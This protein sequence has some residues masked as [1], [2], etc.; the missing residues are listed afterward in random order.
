MDN[1]EFLLSNHLPGHHGVPKPS[2]KLKGKSHKESL[3]DS[4]QRCPNHG[5]S[6]SDR[7]HHSKDVILIGKKD[8]GNIIPPDYHADVKDDAKGF[9]GDTT[10]LVERAYAP[11]SALRQN[12]PYFFGVYDPNVA[13]RYNQDFDITFP[14]FNHFENEALIHS[15]EAHHEKNMPA[16]MKEEIK[17]EIIETTRRDRNIKV[18]HEVHQSTLTPK[19]KQLQSQNS[20]ANVKK[21]SKNAS[22]NENSIWD[23]EGDE[24]KKIIDFWAS[25]NEVER[26]RLIKL[27]KESVTKKMKEQQ[28]HSCTCNVC[29]RRRTAIEE[30]LEM[31]YDAYYEELEKFTKHRD[32]HSDFEFFKS[33]SSGHSSMLNLTDDLMK[34]EGKKFV[35]MMEKLADRR[36]RKDYGNP[37][38][39][40]DNDDDDCSQ[41]EDHKLEN[42]KNMFQVFAAKMFEQRILAAYREKMALEKQRKLIE[43]EE[44]RTKAEQQKKESKQ[45]QRDKKKKKK[46]IKQE[47][48]KRRQ[49]E[50]KRKQEEEKKKREEE[51]RK[52]ELLEK[53]QET[54]SKN[55]I[56]STQDK[57]EDIEEKPLQSAPPP[58][59]K[60][61][62]KKKKSKTTGIV[63]PM[64][65]PKEPPSLVTKKP[66]QKP[67]QNLPTTSRQ[68]KVSKN[69]NSVLDSSKTKD[70]VLVD[71]A[72]S[73]PKV[74]PSESIRNIPKVSKPSKKKDNASNVL[75]KDDDIFEPNRTQKDTERR[76]I[77]AFETLR[78]QL[79]KKNAFIPIQARKF[80]DDI[81]YIDST[82]SLPGCPVLSVDPFKFLKKIETLGLAILGTIENKQY[83]VV[84]LDLWYVIVTDKGPICLVCNKNNGDQCMKPCN[85]AICSQCI[86]SYK[87]SHQPIGQIGQVELT[88]C[89]VCKKDVESAKKPQLYKLYDPLSGIEIATRNDWDP[90][91]DINFIDSQHESI[92]F[93][94]ANDSYFNFVS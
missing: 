47:E 18:S 46:K 42:A 88:H 67:V 66:N 32:E 40:D 44:E 71:E 83:D 33:F 49:E 16:K 61:K 86:N 74:E 13:I 36:I 90:F 55:E 68:E 65:P 15:L 38:H 3:H 91:S 41:S 23:D 7:P 24:R 54:D 28:K 20:R 64:E 77:I 25:L 84:S 82:L 1:R 2:S 29:G 26:N 51:Q 57:E 60:K 72:P 62:K 37:D 75:S 59:K 52:K 87:L 53:E 21:T 34:N 14:S 22:Y 93:D 30:E 9:I 89:L 78:S 17:K 19:S 80:W 94:N 4:C 92:P 85:H 5:P 69:T 63:V 43:E 73:L 70:S 6:T 10:R 58:S 12:T 39:S 45:R 48:E 27:E 8:Y 35:E 50:E 56:P 81:S 11:A 76:A 79:I 31:L